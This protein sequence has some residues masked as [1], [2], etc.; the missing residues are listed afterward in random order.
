MFLLLY[1]TNF[2]LNKTLKQASGWSDANNGEIYSWVTSHGTSVKPE[3][4]ADLDNQICAGH[5]DKNGVYDAQH[6]IAPGDDGKWF[7]DVMKY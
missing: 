7:I 6:G 3:H 1:G 5:K 2:V 4:F